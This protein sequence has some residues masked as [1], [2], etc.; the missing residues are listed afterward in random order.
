MSRK[1][2]P[3]DFPLL[4]TV[5]TWHRINRQW[6]PRT[7]GSCPVCHLALDP[8][9]VNRHAKAC[10]RRK[11]EAPELWREWLRDMNAAG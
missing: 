6:P 3:K 4:F 5:K 9:L 1:P 10:A 2:S 7:P 11:R 8:R